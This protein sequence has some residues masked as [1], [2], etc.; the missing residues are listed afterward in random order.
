MVSGK[1]QWLH[2][3]KAGEVGQ[4]HEVSD[5]RLVETTWK[6]FAY[7]HTCGSSSHP[8]LSSLLDRL[9]TGCAIHMQ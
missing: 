8:Y 1:P 2:W 7:I 9:T 5:T 6:D 4:I 3:V